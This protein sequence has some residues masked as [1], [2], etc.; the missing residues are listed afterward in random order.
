M[1]Y[2][3][4]FIGSGNVAWNLAHALDKYGHTIIQIISRNEESAKA[5]AR[6]FGAYHGT[7]YTDLYGDS[8][9]I[10]VSVNDD[11]YADVIAELHDIKAILIH[12]SGPQPM[13]MLS[14]SAQRYGVFYPLQ[15]LNKFILKDFREVPLLVEGSTVSVEIE[16]RDLADSISNHVKE[17]NSEDRMRYHLAAVFANNFTNLMYSCSERY[18]EKEGLDFNLL[19]P[20]IFETALRI[21]EESPL[22]LQTG[23]AKR[24]DVKV[25]DKH[26]E[27]LDDPR[28]REVYETLSKLIMTFY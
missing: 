5:L 13:S 11:S 27:M 24:K 17:V 1:Q 8:D 6:K 14:K 7:K 25:I 3:I 28:L 10:F 21:K 2:K 15:S 18:L 12:T 26:V 19:K 22:N 16:L 9:L 4:T 20:I 23:P